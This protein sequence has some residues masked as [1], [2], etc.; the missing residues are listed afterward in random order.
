MPE[1][2][3][4]PRRSAPDHPVLPPRGDPQGGYTLNDAPDF[5]ATNAPPAAPT[6]PTAPVVNAAGSPQDTVAGYIRTLLGREPQPGEVEAQLRGGSND[7]PS[8]QR[9]LQASDEAKTWAVAHPAGSPTGKPS[10]QDFIKSYQQSHPIS[11]GIGPLTAAMKAAGYNVT[12]FMYGQTA[13]HNELSVDGVKTK[14]IAAEDTP[15]AN[16]FAAGTNDGGGGSGMGLGMAGPT[17]FGTAPA[18]YA[19]RPWTGGD[20]VDP[21]MA[22]VQAGPGYQTRLDAG[23]QAGNRSAA[24]NGTLLNGGTQKALARYGQDYAQNEFQTARGNKLQSYQ[25]RYGQFMDENNRSLGD[26]TVNTANK[27]N[28]D[29]DY[30]S[31]LRDLYSG[32]ASAAAGSYKPPA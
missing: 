11:E 29:L 27:R 24:A 26:Y 14:V 32:G 19:S 21:T 16:W 8:I 22:E 5:W 18:P 1:K 20:F 10:A 17:N 25:Q 6:T 7:L 12:P 3:T 4:G 28:A 2:Y 23:L 13:S 30:W 31:R 15:G 9:A